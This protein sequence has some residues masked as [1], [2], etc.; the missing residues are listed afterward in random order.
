MHMGV[1]R[2]ADCARPMLDLGTHQDGARSTDGR[3]QGTYLHGLFASDG[4]RHAY[5]NRLRHRE[6]QGPA[7]EATVE[8]ALD[9]LAAHLE[10]SLDLD[11]LM[12]IAR[13]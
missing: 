4:F 9:A 7:Y 3:I 12:E 5:L 13:A 2:G 10:Q 6:T 11:R 8:A 1:T